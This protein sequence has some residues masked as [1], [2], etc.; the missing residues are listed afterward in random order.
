[1]Y[2][3]TPDGKVTVLIEH[4]GGMESYPSG[5]SKG[6]NGMVTDK[7]GS[8]LM[9][10]HGARRIDQCAVKKIRG[11]KVTHV[12]EIGGDAWAFSIDGVATRAVARARE[13]GLPA[14]NVAHHDSL[15]VERAHVAQVGN[16]SGQLRSAESERQH[17]CTRDSVGDRGPQIIVRNDAL[18]NAG[19]KINAGNEIAGRTVAR[20][21]LRRENLR[22]VL[23][24]RRI[25]FRRAVLPLC[26][27]GRAAKCNVKEVAERAEPLRIQKIFANF[28][29]KTLTLRQILDLA[30]PLL[31]S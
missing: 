28:H 17:A 24:V 26:T 29:E 3:I 18:E 14:S 6:S 20:R 5:M 7:D 31:I 16:D 21:T 13:Q 23:N 27:N 25:I 11:T 22:A 8:V 30:H 2:A 9:T 1:M 19:T 12:A 10:Q 4:A 15:S